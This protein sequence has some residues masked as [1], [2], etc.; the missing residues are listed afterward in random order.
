[1]PAYE[2]RCPNCQ[3]RNRVPKTASGRPQCG[4]CGHDLP[5]L[6]DVDAAEFDRVVATSSLPVLV[7]LWAPWCGPCRVVA[8]LLESL[9]SE[10]A[11]SL[12]ILKVDIDQHPA[13]PAR[14]GVQSIPTMVLFSNGEEV[15]R[16]IGAVPGDRL[17][18]WV[19]QALAVGRT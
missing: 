6:F 13:V 4:R 2:V 16:Q 17:A 19:D 5:S 11:G 9:A 7:D 3:K 1:M 12:R 18:A 15:A 8:P 14:L 10:R